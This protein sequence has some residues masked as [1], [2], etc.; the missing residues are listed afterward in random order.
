LAFAGDPHKLAVHNDSGLDMHLRRR[1]LHFGIALVSIWLAMAAYAVLQGLSGVLT[2]HHY[3]FAA[4]DLI[5]SQTVYIWSPLLP[6]T[7]LVFWFATRN[8]FQPDRWWSSLGRHLLMML[9]FSLLH[10]YLSA[11]LYYRIGL[12]EEGMHGYRPWQHTGHFLFTHNNVFLLD[13]LIYSILVASQ[14]ISQFHRRVRRQEL[15]AATLEAQLAES[16]LR[17]LKMQVNP[18][19][20]FNTLNSI[21]VLVKKGE[22]AKADE[23]LTLLSAFFRRTLEQSEEQTVCLQRELDLIAQYLAIEQVRFGERLRVEY[24]IDADCRDMHVPLLILQ[25]LVENAIKHGLGGK[26]GPC[27]LCISVQKAAEGLIL[28]VADDGAGTAEA[29]ADGIGL[30]NVRK[31]LWALYRD[32]QCVDFESAPG[33]GTCVSITLGAS[34]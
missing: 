20:L 23:M 21:S 14:N 24:R 1:L 29:R 7:P 8:P 28:S 19:F 22:N 16:K 25:P 30:D 27:H 18:H 4:W 26:V 17:A 15:D 32:R 13:L 5:R 2:L 9:A 10:G 34:A 3:R 6:L 31:R 11:L 33:R 12:I